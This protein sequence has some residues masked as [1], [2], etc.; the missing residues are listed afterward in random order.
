VG[1]LTEVRGCD[2][3][4]FTEERVDLGILTAVQV[5]RLIYYRGTG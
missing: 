2:T 4:S 5:D 1:Y 3:G